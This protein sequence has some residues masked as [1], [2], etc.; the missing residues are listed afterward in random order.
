MLH[1]IPEQGQV[2]LASGGGGAF[3]LREVERGGCTLGSLGSGI[4]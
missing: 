4:S 1:E 3:R 2:Y